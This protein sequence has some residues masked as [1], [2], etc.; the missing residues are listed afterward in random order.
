[1]I[2]EGVVNNLKKNNEYPFGENISMLE[3]GKYSLHVSVGTR[4][5]TPVIA[6]PLNC[7]NN[8]RRYHLGE[9][10]VT[11]SNTASSKSTAK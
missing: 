2:N 6:L 10:I 8:G 9:I 1:M 4:D 5:G 11:P 3:P 7:P